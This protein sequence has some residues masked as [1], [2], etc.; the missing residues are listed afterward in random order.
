M[1]L[2]VSLS[3][4]TPWIGWLGADEYAKRRGVE[5]DRLLA[6]QV[7]DLAADLRPVVADRISHGGGDRGERAHQLG[8]PLATDPRQAEAASRSVVAAAIAI[9]NADRPSKALH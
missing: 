3:R 2:P 8:D 6:R 5:D 4:I 9:D 7:L 1:G